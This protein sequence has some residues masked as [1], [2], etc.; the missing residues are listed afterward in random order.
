MTFAMPLL[1]LYFRLKRITWASPRQLRFLGFR[2]RRRGRRNE[3]PMMNILLST[4]HSAC[5][6]PSFPMFLPFVPLRPPRC[7]FVPLHL[8]KIVSPWI[9]LIP[10]YQLIFGT[11]AFQWWAAQTYPSN[12][13]K[14][15]FQ[16]IV[17]QTSDTSRAE[18]LNWAADTLTP[19]CKLPE[20]VA[21]WTS[22]DL[23]YKKPLPPYYLDTETTP[24]PFLIKQ[25]N[26]QQH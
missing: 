3:C 18:S 24:N 19:G 11:S 13:I 26:F 23:L 1:S 16:A 15:E 5:L 10:S 7:S 14:E 17:K 9:N 8:L 20:F 22:T 6:F 2:S 21:L 12:K 25:L 4:Q